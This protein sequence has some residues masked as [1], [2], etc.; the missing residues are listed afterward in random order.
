MKLLFISFLFSFMVFTSCNQSFVFGEDIDINSKGWHKDSTLV[1]YSDSLTELP[2]LIKIGF[3]IRNDI[4]YYFRNIYLFIEINIPGK[5]QPIQD[6]INHLLMTPEGYWVDGVK[7]ANIKESMAYY[8]YAIKNPPKG[9]YTIKIQ[10]GM[11]DKVLKGLVSIGSRIER[12][13]LK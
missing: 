5:E 8:P 11:R 13:D 9:V 10:Q 4:D 1:F 6:T 12:V 3:N 2:P 7:G